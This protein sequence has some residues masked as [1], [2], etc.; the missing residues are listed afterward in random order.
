MTLMGEHRVHLAIR[1]ELADL[2][3][4]SDALEQFC[5]RHGVTSKTRGHLQVALDEIVSNIIKYAWPDGGAHK[6]ELFISAVTDG[7]KLELVD[8]GQA[9]DPLAVKAPAQPTAGSRP[10]PGGLGLHMVHQLVDGIDYVRRRGR[11]HTT[12]TKQCAVSVS[13]RRSR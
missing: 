4:L 5:V 1:N 2:A 9:F 7:I 12:L 10:R 13:S 11:N 8:D 6:I 3:L